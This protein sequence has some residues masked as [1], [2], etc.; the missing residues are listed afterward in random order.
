MIIHEK[1][2]KLLQKL[3]QMKTKNINMQRYRYGTSLTFSVL[4]EHKVKKNYPRK[5]IAKVL[6]MFPP[7]VIYSGVR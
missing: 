7:N 6:I 4:L 2:S 5:E 1:I 3:V